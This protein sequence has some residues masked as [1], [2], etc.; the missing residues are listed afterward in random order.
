MSDNSPLR[1]GLTGGIGSG[2]STVAA[3]F[4]KLGITLIDADQIAREV[5]AP[6]TDAYQAILTHFGESILD[7]HNHIDRR[8]LRQRIFDQ[9]DERRWLEALLHPLIRATMIERANCANSPYCIMVIPLLTESNNADYVDRI[10]VVDAPEALQIARV[11]ARDHIDEAA[12]KTMMAAQNTRT[13]RIQ[14]ADDIILNDGNPTE[15]HER[16]AALDQHYRTLTHEN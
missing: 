6:N 14:K 4:E 7:K 3:C 12:V 9:T 8:A 11:M 1:I 10:L 5:V 15:L 2:K 16:V 13:A